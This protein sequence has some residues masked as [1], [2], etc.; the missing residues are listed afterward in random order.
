MVARSFL[1]FGFVAWYPA[2]PSWASGLCTAAAVFSH[3]A[4]PACM[5]GPWLTDNSL[6]GVY[7]SH[8]DGANPWVERGWSTIGLE[9][10]HLHSRM[11]AVVYAVRE[12]MIEIS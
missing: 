3:P 1:V 4:T 9:K 5:F 2:A 8:S 11:E 10:L 7:T 12:K 6:L